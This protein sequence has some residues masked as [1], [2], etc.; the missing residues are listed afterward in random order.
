LLEIA[1]AVQDAMKPLNSPIQYV[2]ERPGQVFRHTCD[3]SKAKEL[4]G[5][6]PSVSFEEGLDETIKWYRDNEAWWRPQVWMRH[7]PIIT[8]SGK[9]E[10]H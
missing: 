6:E 10:L 1:K 7:I 3:G 2:G 5:W 8:A 9:R 4:L